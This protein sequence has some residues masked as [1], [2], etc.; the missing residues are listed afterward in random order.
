[1]Y[2]FIF[3]RYAVVNI[4]LGSDSQNHSKRYDTVNGFIT[5]KER[6][7]RPKGHTKICGVDR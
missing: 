6:E 5:K 2:L 3:L 1:M 7:V 4:K